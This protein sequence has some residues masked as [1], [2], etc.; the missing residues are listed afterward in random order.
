MALEDFEVV[1]YSN[2]FFPIV[3]YLSFPF[4]SCKYYYCNTNL[5]YCPLIFQ[6]QPYGTGSLSSASTNRSI[7]HRMPTM[8]VLRNCQSSH[9]KHDSHYDFVL[10]SNQCSFFITYYVISRLLCMTFNLL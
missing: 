2:F 7:Q 8:Q 9:S 6:Q 3:L 4:K 10:L 1:K 5:C